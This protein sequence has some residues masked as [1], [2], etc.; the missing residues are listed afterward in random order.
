MRH[1]TR[2][3]TSWSTSSGP[4]TRALC[5]RTFCGLLLPHGA[6][7]TA[8]PQHPRPEELLRVHMQTD[9]YVSAGPEDELELDWG[10]GPGT[11]GLK[12]PSIA[13]EPVDHGTV[14]VRHRLT[15]G[16]LLGI[17]IGGV[18]MRIGEVRKPGKVRFPPW[19]GGLCGHDDPQ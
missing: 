6:C 5:S 13:A 3:S 2:R 12:L 9:Q 18:L 14:E 1:S 8:V 10:A 16:A 19:R 7:G 15:H 4:R 17:D 11:K